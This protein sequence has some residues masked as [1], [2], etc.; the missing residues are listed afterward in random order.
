MKT[1]KQKTVRTMPV[2]LNHHCRGNILCG[3]FP[4]GE[5]KHFKDVY[6][7]IMEKGN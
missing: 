1:G 2:S 5:D 6:S 7:N 4:E 3:K